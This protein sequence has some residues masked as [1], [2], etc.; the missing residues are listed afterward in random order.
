MMLVIRGIKM[1]TYE[2]K[3]YS[4]PRQ[5][6]HYPPPPYEYPKMRAMVCL[7]KAPIDVKKQFLPAELEPVEFPFDAIFI[8]EYPDSSI[9]PY[10]ENLILLYCKYKKDPGLFVMNI[11][12]D[13]DEA[14]TAGREI[15]GYPKKMCNIS[16]SE[17]E[18]NKVMGKLVRKRKTI[19]EAEAELTEKAPGLDPE[20][21]VKSFPLI[22]L[23]LIPD[24]E[25]NL[26]PALK[27]L[28]A[29]NIEWKNFTLKRGLNVQ[30]LKSE[31]S[32]YDI[33]SEILKVSDL[34]LGGFY[35]ECDQILPNGR[36]LEDLL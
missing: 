21:I 27:Q 1:T 7:F 25:D 28:T 5:C 11:Y 4:M 26:N 23:K 13:D 18:N 33:C 6:G 12:V 15:W 17:I 22:N 19:I 35:I 8:A 2:M 9:G 31:F 32:E 3:D 14:L 16:L 36:L 30:S 34:N 10:N 24:V 20:Y 29:T